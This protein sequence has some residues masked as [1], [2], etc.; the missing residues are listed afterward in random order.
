MCHDLDLRSYLKGQ[1]EG[2]SSH[3][4]TIHAQAIQIVRIP[5]KPSQAPANVNFHR[6]ARALSFKPIWNVRAAFRCWKVSAKKACVK[7]HIVW[8]AIKIYNLHWLYVY[9]SIEFA[10]KTA[11]IPWEIRS[12]SWENLTHYRRVARRTHGSTCFHIISAENIF[13]SFTLPISS[14]VSHIL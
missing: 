6:I 12:N 5:P 10:Q 11:Q 2:Y 8:H 7:I 9:V 4:L 1:L 3:I 13:F 14:S